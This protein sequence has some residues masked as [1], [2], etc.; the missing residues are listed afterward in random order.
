MNYLL[1]SSNELNNSFFV[2]FAH[3]ID[4]Q[5][6]TGKICNLLDINQKS[7]REQILRF[8][9][10]YTV[11]SE[12]EYAVKSPDGSK[13]I[14]D[15]LLR[16]NSKQTE[17]DIAF[18]IIE[19]KISK[20]AIKKGQIENQYNYFSM[21]EEY[22]A[23]KPVYSILI[24][25]DDKAF[26]KLYEPATHKNILTLWLKWLNHTDNEISIEAVLR[27]LIKHE[28]NAEIEP[29]DPNTQFII[30]SFVD[31][32]ATEFAQ[33]ENGKKNYSYKGFDVVGIAQTSL[34]KNKYT[35]KRF[36]NNMVRL[37]DENDELLE[38][39]VRPILREINSKYGFDIDLYHSTGKAKNT[40]IFGREIINKLN[41]N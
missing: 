2:L 38:I 4:S 31:Y 11:S 13:Q 10:N 30:K 6:E 28:H 23:D 29:I 12:P 25:P 24:S 3:L 34:G 7:I 17:E 40:Q 39:D 8:T 21:S 1:D 15:I 19:N 41:N 37:F 5:L 14:P 22:D 18:I 35:I 27:N 32:L 9:E 20:T 16:I 26:Q 36:S 33:K